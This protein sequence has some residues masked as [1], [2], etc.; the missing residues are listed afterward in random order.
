VNILYEADATP[1]V[2]DDRTIG[3]VGY[4]A[5][6][7]AHARNLRDSGARVVVAE[8]AGS[9]AWQQAQADAFT[10]VS[11]PDAVRASDI[12]M[13]LLPDELHGDVFEADVAPHMHPGIYLGFAHGFSILYRH[14]IPA[15]DVNVF[16]VAPKA[17][18][19]E[20]RRRYEKGGGVPCLMAVEQDPAGDTRDVA[21]GYACGIGGG[22]AGIIETTFRDETETDLFGE[23][24]VLC[25]GLSELIRAGFETL[26]DAG[27]RPE[28]AY[29][30]CLH[31]VKIIAD[32]IHER[33]IAGMREVISTTARFGDLTRGRRVIAA[34]VRDA[35]QQLLAEIRSGQFADEFTAACRA[36][37]DAV[38]ARAE[39]DAGHPI[40]TVG[41]RLRSALPLA[42]PPA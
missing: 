21:L 6:G 10:V 12:L 7:H 16:L 35:M 4:G 28:L 31:E 40:E 11:T 42:G 20:V 19:H 9:T 23:Q 29:F 33:G 1:G 8:R 34:P 26:V 27:Y 41:Q 5:Q 25:G 22:R 39:Q 38:R 17:Q 2:L 15:T 37:D 14:V 24:A 32:L 3:I 18:G 13:L 30:E 36:G